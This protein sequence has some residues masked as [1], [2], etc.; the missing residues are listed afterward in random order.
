MN[1]MMVAETLVAFAPAQQAVITAATSTKF[2]AGK[3]TGPTTQLEA[4]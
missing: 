3:A 1:A 2:V 4:T